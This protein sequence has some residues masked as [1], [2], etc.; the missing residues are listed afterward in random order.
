MRAVVIADI[1]NR[2]VFFMFGILVV[3]F[4]LPCIDWVVYVETTDI[5]KG[6]NWIG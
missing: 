4:I 2:V 3:L 1:I 5:S 6:C